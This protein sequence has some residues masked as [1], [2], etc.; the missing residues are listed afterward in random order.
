MINKNALVSFYG[1]VSLLKVRCP[2]CGLVGIVRNGTMACC[3]VP[4]ERPEKYKTKRE[5]ESE[6]KR[7]HL[8]IYMKREILANQGNRCIYCEKRFDGAVFNSIKNKWIPLKI[9]F[10]HA[11]AWKFSGDNQQTN[12]V[13]A[14]HICNQIKYDFLFDD[15]EKARKF[16]LHRRQING[17]EDDMDE[18]YLNDFS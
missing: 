17:Y 2:E 8:S 9:H 3:N 14:C 7:S 13:A 5:S 4:V 6:R 12:I 15:L 11:V 18:K 10:D 16:I 1:G